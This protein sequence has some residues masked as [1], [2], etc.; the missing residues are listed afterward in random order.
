MGYVKQSEIKPIVAKDYILAHWREYGLTDDKAE[1]IG[2][3]NVLQACDES[4]NSLHNAY[5]NGYDEFCDIY[6]GKPWN[7]DKEIVDALFSFCSFFTEKEFIEYILDKRE[8][9]ES[10]EEYVEFMRLDATDEPDGNNDTQ[11]SRTDDGYVC[12]VWY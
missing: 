6:H 2:L 10:E 11:I 8:D 9:Y 3:L 12:R 4:I 7:S 1:F 5:I